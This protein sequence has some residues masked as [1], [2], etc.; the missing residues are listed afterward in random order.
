V[1]LQAFA[2]LV[3][4]V[5]LLEIS[6]AF[7]T[8]GPQLLTVLYLLSDLIQFSLT[9]L[10]PLV[11][12]FACAF[13]VLRGETGRAV[14]FDVGFAAALE[15]LISQTLNGEPQILRTLPFGEGGKGEVGDGEAGSGGDV[16]IDVSAFLLMTLFGFVVVVLLLSMV[17][18]RFSRT[19]ATVSQSIDANYKLK[20]AQITVAYAARLR[21]SQLAPQP[22]NLVRRLVLLLFHDLPTMLSSAGGILTSVPRTSELSNSSTAMAEPC[23]AADLPKTVE[24]FL[25]RA[26]SEVKLFPEFIA[27][28]CA[29]QEYLIAEECGRDVS[30]HIMETIAELTAMGEEQSAEQRLIDRA[31]HAHVDSLRAHL[32]VLEEG[33]HSSEGGSQAAPTRRETS[34]PPMLGAMGRSTSCISVLRARAARAS[35]DLGVDLRNGM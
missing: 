30:H 9:L 31:L 25:H 35:K 28:H 15:V 1:A 32:L 12:A 16:S 20:F 22:F 8:A 2:T 27:E 13:M 4:W 17:I 10:F 3:A 34:Q 19:F 33:L 7:P 21:S 29:S 11:V 5:R 6:Y 23:S 26:V 24:R 14:G 18:A